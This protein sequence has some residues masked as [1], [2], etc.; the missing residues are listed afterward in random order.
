MNNRQ[1]EWHFA[2]GS[3]PC[4]FAALGLNTTPEDTTNHGMI[5]LTIQFAG[6]VYII[7]FKVVELTAKGNAL[8]QIKAKKYHEKYSG[9]DIYLIGIEFS[10]QDRN[11]VKFEWEEIKQPV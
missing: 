3:A 1:C 10:S 8:E 11:I 5:D 9:N 6:K 4:Y 7:E 2:F